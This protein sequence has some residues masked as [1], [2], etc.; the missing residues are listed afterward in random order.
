M[1][2]KR[3]NMKRDWLVLAVLVMATV[4]GLS[5]A[6]L[7]SETMSR[8]EKFSYPKEQVTESEYLGVMVRMDGPSAGSLCL[9]IITS[10]SQTVSITVKDSRVLLELLAFEL[11]PFTGKYKEWKPVVR[12]PKRSLYQTYAVQEIDVVGRFRLLYDADGRE[13]YEKEIYH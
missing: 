5:R 6:Q 1:N 7:L 2:G 4:P 3:T 11:E 9:A 8:I 10:D 12:F 13:R